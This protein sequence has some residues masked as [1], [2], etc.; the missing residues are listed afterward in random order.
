[1][2]LGTEV[3][4]DPGHIVFDG[5]PLPPKGYSPSFLS[6]SVVAKRLDGSRCHL[7]GTE[8]GLISGDI[9]LDRDPAPEEGTQQPPPTCRPMAIVTKRL[10]GSRYHL[11]RR[12]GRSVGV[13]GVLSTPGQLGQ[14]R[15]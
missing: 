9:V 2:P 10:D 14:H 6:M 3:G 1:M 7:V 11:V 13:L 5:H 4:V 12:P 15:Y 8:V